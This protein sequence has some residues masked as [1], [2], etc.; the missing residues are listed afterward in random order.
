M[1]TIDERALLRKVAESPELLEIGRAAIE[2]VLIDY[3]ESRISTLNRGNGLVVREKNGEKSSLIR[4]GPEDG[5][6]IGL[7]AIADSL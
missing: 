7:T 1:L 2:A 3:R 6:R 4:L 5:L